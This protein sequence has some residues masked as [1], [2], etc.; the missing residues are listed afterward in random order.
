MAETRFFI[1]VDLGQSS[2][3]TAIA[4]VR[5]VGEE[6]VAVFQVGH[7]ERVPLHTPYPAIV[8]RVQHLLSHPICAG[9][10]D[11][12][13]DQTGVGGPVADM[14]R[15]AGI[16]FTGVVITGG[17]EE[18]S[19]SANLAHVPKLKLISH[20]QALLH[21]G[22]LLIQ[23]N[24]PEAPILVS[25]LQ[26]FR[27]RYSDSG[28]L[29]F[30]AR[31]GKH[32]DLVLALAIAVW[33]AVRPLSGAEGWCRLYEAWSRGE[34][35][36]GG[37]SR[38]NTDFDPIRPAGD[39]F[40]FSFSTEPLVNVFVPPVLASGMRGTRFLEGQAYLQLTQS[41]AKEQLR[42]PAWLALNIELAKTLGI[43]EET[44]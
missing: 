26:N 40:N 19:P 37:I 22:R 18:T 43:T 15:Q 35:Y 30:N 29:T 2:D 31:E 12:A 36:G 17:Q 23:K 39:P 28:H 33:L 6:R 13:I 5:R 14:F 24:L 32:D 25:E 4:M 44:A 20:L 8:N 10:A 41:E 3:P 21:E 38:A 42:H 7:L 9:N 1:G 27:V 34:R 16:D 11:L